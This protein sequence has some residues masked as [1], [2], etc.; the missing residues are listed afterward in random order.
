MR[1]KRLTRFYSLLAL[2]YLGGF[3]GFA[4]TIPSDKEDLEKGAGAGMAKYAD[5][6][7]YPG[8]KHILELQDTLKL[9]DKQKREI[10]AL[11]NEMKS[12][13]VAKGMLIVEKERKLEALF[14]NEQATPTEVHSLST[15][16]GKLRGELRAVHMNTHIKAKEILTKEQATLYNMIR[17]GSKQLKHEA[18]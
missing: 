8:P 1:R 17:H 3:T 7:G 11:F 6:N 12:N 2:L 13:A 15:E 9:S 14:R 10:E 5:L 18:H 4:Q 16:I